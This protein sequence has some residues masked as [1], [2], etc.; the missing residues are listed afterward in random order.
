MKRKGQSSLE[1]AFIV[2]FIMIAISGIF[3]KAMQYSHDIGEMARARTIAQAVA[4]ELSLNGTRT[5]IIRLDP[6]PSPNVVTL[7]VRGENCSSGVENSFDSALGY[8][9]LWECNDSLY[10]A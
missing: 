7:F 8:N 10:G 3:G 4:L 6:A 5:H 1:A 2:L 9:A